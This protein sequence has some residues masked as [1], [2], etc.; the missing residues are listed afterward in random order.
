MDSYES[1]AIFLNGLPKPEHHDTLGA[2]VHHVS[3]FKGREYPFHLAQALLLNNHLY[4]SQGYVYVVK[5]CAE[6]LRKLPDPEGHIDFYAQHLEACCLVTD[7]NVPI[8]T[9][10]ATVSTNSDTREQ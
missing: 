8:V 4:G 2:L 3:Q 5:K 6:L 1:E 10:L 9:A 7:V